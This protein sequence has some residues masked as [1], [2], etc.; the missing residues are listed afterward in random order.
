MNM[1]TEASKFYPLLITFRP[2]QFSLGSMECLIIGSL[3]CSS[4]VLAAISLIKYE[5]QPQ[6]FSI[7][8]GEGVTNDAVSIILFNT[9]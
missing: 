2:V 5:E 1:F 9:V 7:I 3:L 4:D 6:V 8:F